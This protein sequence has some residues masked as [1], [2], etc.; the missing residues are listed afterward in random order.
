MSFKCRFTADEKLQK[1]GAPRFIR[2]KEFDAT[3]YMQQF[4][5]IGK[6][7]T[8]NEQ[9]DY[10]DTCL[11]ED[12]GW[13]AFVCGQHPE[14]IRLFAYALFANY[15]KTSNKLDWHHV[16]G[17][18]WD[19]YLDSVNDPP[20]KHLVVLDSLL[21]HPPMHPSGN[22][23]YDPARL[24]KIYDITAKHRGKTSIVILCPGL[25]PEEAYHLSMIQFDMAFSLRY[26]AKTMEL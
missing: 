12:G 15:S 21:T 16:T 6:V 3:E 18:R 24:G 11:N 10:L 5:V 26:R 25:L 4:E 9:V 23:G 14:Q 7:V 13:V 8:S 1:L 17:S 22:R 2:C 20:A 19:K